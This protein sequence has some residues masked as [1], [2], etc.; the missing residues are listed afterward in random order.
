MTVKDE[1]I[2]EIR[3][4]RC[5]I[6]AKCGNDVRAFADYME[7]QNA[8][9]AQ[10]VAAWKKLEENRSH[11]TADAPGEIETSIVGEEPPRT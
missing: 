4:P 2:E 11:R 7:K 6:S 1:I 8:L 9:F 5:E 10:Q 3:R